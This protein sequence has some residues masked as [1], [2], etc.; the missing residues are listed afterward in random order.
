MSVASLFV[1][2]SAPMDECMVDEEFDNFELMVSDDRKEVRAKKLFP[3]DDLSWDDMEE[4]GDELE[5][6]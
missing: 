2:T 5:L 4:A 3:G 1:S 6:M